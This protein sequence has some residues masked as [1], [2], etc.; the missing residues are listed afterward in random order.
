MSDKQHTLKES[1][2]ISGQGLHTGASVTITFHPAAENHGVVFKRIDVEGQPEIKAKAEFVTDTMRGT[3]I[4]RDG[5]KVHTVEHA[6]SAIVGNGI[7]NV[8]IELDGPEV[9]ILDGSAKP[10]TD[11][12][13]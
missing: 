12:I 1:F 10:F 2:S 8:L 9:P 11:L 5:V 3:S 13:S 7:D 6:L 4:G